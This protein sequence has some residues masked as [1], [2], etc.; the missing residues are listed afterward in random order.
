MTGRIMTRMTT[1]VEALSASCCRPG[2]STPSCSC[3]TFVGVHRLLVVMNAA[4]G[5]G[6][7][8]PSCRR[9]SLATLVVPP[10]SRRGLRAGPRP[11]RRRQRQPA[12]E[13]LGR[14]GGP[15][16][17][18]RGAQHG[19]LPRRGRRVP[20]RPPRRP[21]AR[22]SRTSRSSSSCRR[23][24]RARARRRAPRS[25]SGGDAHGRR[26][27]RLPALPRPVLLPDPAAVAGVRH[28]PAGAGRR[29]TRSPS[30]WARRR[31]HAR[32]PSARSTPG[33]SPGEVRFEDVHVRATPAPAEPRPCRRRPR[34][35]PPGETVAL[36]GE[37]G[38]GKSTL[39]KLVGPL[40][41][42]H[43][44]AGPGRRHRPAPTSTS[45][46]TA[47]QLG[48]VPQEA[49]LF[50]GHDPRQHRLRP[51]RR[52]RRRGRGGGPGRRRPRL[53]RRPARR[54]PTSR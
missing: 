45:P 4:A 27:H 16:V 37:T 19:R 18:P 17:R 30:C 2:S 39:V 11:H 34:R 22:R 7:C 48:F 21:A 8:W 40:L 54:L 35:S 29:W 20:R 47:S 1:D 49:F 24:R 23:G 15:G 41:R 10:A 25:C 9:W 42:P 52:H 12:G 5:P 50:T 33:G 3:V 14:A 51:A 38:A 46:P 13:P 43:R 28:L 6:A 53:R 31:R 32:A 44:R 36:V 26:A